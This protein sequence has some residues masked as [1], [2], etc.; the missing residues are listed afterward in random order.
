MPWPDML[1][2][3]KLFASLPPRVLAEVA[4]QFVEE[5]VPRGGY[6]F[7]QGD[8]SLWLYILTAGRVRI[9]KHS[10][11]GRDLILEMISPGEVFGGVAALNQKPYPASAQATEPSTVR[12]LSRAYLLELMERHP[13]MGLDAA[14]FITQRLLEAHAMMREIAVERVESRIAFALLKLAEKSGV[15]EGQGIRL[16]LGVTRQEL[17]DMVGTTVET[18]IRVMSRLRKQGLIGNTGGRIVIRDKDRLRAL[19]HGE[20]AGLDNTGALH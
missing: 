15:P 18:A 3:I 20:E 19:A 17:A 13:R 14:E 16:G 2:N 8:P 6:V 1:H 10:P 12:K 7:H 4:E 9:I 11:S 5:Q